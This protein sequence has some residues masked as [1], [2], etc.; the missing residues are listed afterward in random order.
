MS[1]LA[2]LGVALVILVGLGFIPA[3]AVIYVVRER[4]QEEKTVQHCSG[5]GKP[6]YWVSVYL[7]DLLVL[8]TGIALC[9]VVIQIFAIQIYVGRSNFPAV[10]LL[11]F[12]FGFAS[13]PLTQIASHLFS[14]PSIAF[15]VSPSLLH[16]KQ[17]TLEM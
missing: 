6:T 8:L 5:V 17:K 10:I 3:S 16:Q 15:M 9:A 2:D 7:W 12:L 1:R 13:L 4:A 14:E 11:L